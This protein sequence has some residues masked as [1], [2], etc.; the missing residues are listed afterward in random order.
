MID[1]TQVYCSARDTSV[2]T[3]LKKRNIAVRS[4]RLLIYSKTISSF[5]APENIK[6][7]LSIAPE[8]I[9]K[10]LVP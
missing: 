8:N 9:K 10:P 2:K 1:N 6:S 3:K 5:I 4:Q 7:P